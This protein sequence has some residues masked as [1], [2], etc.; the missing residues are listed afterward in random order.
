M[1]LLKSGHDT[2]RSKATLGAA[3]AVTA[4]LA[5]AGCSASYVEG[6]N[7]SVLLLVEDIAGGAP[8]LSDVR[9]ENGLILNCQADVT[10]SARAKNPNSPVGTS[11]DVRITRYSVSYRRSD[12]RGAQGVDVPYTIS[13]NT[14]VLVEAGGTGSVQLPIDLVRHQAKL[15]PPLS[16]ITGLQIVTMFADVTISGQTVSGK[17][18]KAS[19]SAQVTFAD[20]ADGTSTCE[21]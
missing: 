12:G 14:T 11:E 8:L 21:G 4:G 13:G 15:E 10:I 19:G 20:F 7:S 18:V 9:G 3:L 1:W 5:L 6:D 16:N 2:R 17:S